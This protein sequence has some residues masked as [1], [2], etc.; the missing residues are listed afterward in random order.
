MLV[1]AV[2]L[3]AS[4][5]MERADRDGWAFVAT[6]V[7]ITAAVVGVSTGLAGF[8]AADSQG[9]WTGLDVDVAKAVAD[10]VKQIATE[11]GTAKRTLR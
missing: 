10:A 6:G 1:A 8:S 4:A 7:A 9:A 11:K 5:A 2:A 3:L